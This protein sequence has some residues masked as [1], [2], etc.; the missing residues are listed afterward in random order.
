ML[1]DRQRLER[2]QA[3]PLLVELHHALGRLGSTLTVMNTGAHPDDEHSGMLAAMRF[4][5]GMHVVIACSTRGEGGQNGIG[6]ERTA[7]LSILRTREL[8]EAAKVLDAD[9]AWLGFGPDDPVHD[10]GFSK[11]GADT[12]ARW[13]RD[14]VIERLVRAYRTHRPDIVIPTFLDVPGQHGHHRAMTEAAEVAVARA[15][16]PEAYPEHFEAGLKPW[17]VAKFYLPAWS[18]G[19]GT[20]DDEVPPPNATVSVSAP[21]NDPATGASYSEMGQWSRLAH[22]SQGMGKWRA[23]SHTEWPLHLKI[24]DNGSENDIR[25]GLPASLRDLAK[26]LNPDAAQALERAST[27]IETAQARFPHRDDIITALAEA[28]DNLDRARL[29]LTDEQDQ[30]LGH[31]LTRKLAEIDDALFLAAGVSATAWAEPAA[32]PPGGETMLSVHAV[33]TPAAQA[34]ELRPVLTE[35]I[36]ASAPE[37]DT[38]MHS[39]TLKVAAS[40]KVGNVYAPGFSSLLGNGPVQV[41][42]TATIGGRHA[43][44]HL[45]LEESRADRPC[46]ICQPRAGGGDRSAEFTPLGRCSGGPPARVASQPLHCGPSR[47]QDREDAQRIF[48]Q[49]RGGSG[50]RPAQSTAAGKWQ[51]RL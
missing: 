42:L 15:A 30:R 29:L 47:H 4:G 11:N 3:R 14:L 8:E 23:T 35:D 40:A 38:A 44:K 6:P 45:D 10:F 20:Y 36:S 2:S 7:S 31:R 33:S 9:I 48:P 17:R 13:G 50:S 22:A 26:E 19:G 25:S 27:A 41:E 21:E 16:D 46:A 34:L 32:V 12:L 28:A 51:A 49:A 43:R 5:Y 1:S 18:G 24:G 37:I 39:Y